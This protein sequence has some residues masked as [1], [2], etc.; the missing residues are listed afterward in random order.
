[1]GQDRSSKVR[2]AK[3][4]IQGQIVSSSQPIPVKKPGFRPKP[5][6][7]N[8]LRRSP[9]YCVPLRRGS[10]ASRKPS[11]RK[12]KANMTKAKATAGKIASCGYERMPEA[13]SEIIDPQ[14]GVGRFTPMPMK[15]R[16]ASVE[17]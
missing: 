2:L 6:F 4:T 14:L 12:L 13:P 17:M 10:S 11:P 9:G 1:M 7:Q 15:L 5:G 8:Q 16:K 3:V